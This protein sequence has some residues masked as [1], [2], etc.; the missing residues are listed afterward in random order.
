MDTA[1]E[2]LIQ[3]L[4]G[5]DVRYQANDDR[6][7]I[8]ADFRCEV[9]TYRVIAMVDQDGSLFQVFGY[10]PLRVPEGARPAIAQTI[11][12]AN[13]GMRVGKFEMDF[14]DGELRFQASQILTE[15]GLD[16]EVIDRMMATT[17][18]MLDLYLPAVLSVIYGN[19][20]PEDAIRFVENEGIADTESDGDLLRDED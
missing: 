18:S 2:K 3:H 5:R 9:G 19:E 16:D 4:D 7:S 17:M 15:E 10:A 12:R 11:V 8:C 14:D 20:L 6:G 1:Y 13:Y